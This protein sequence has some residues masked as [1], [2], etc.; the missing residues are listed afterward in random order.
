MNLAS[1]KVFLFDWDGTVFNSMDIK[2]I[3]FVI[4]FVN[5]YRSIQQFDAEVVRNLYIKFSGLPR[6]KLF[7]NVS[8]VLNCENINKAFLLFD[9]LFSELNRE[10]LKEGELFEDAKLFIDKISRSNARM[11]ISS[12]VPE[13]ELLTITKIILKPQYDN[14]EKIMGTTSKHQKGEQHVSEICKITGCKRK[15]L[16]FFGDDYEDY[17]LS[18]IAGVDCIIIDRGQRYSEKNIP[19]AKSFKE[20]SDIL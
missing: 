4:A 11:F 19:T 8:Q 9:K 18:M 14:F 13:K 12:S 20:L 5:S 15:D 2:R 1:K 7:I 16:Q 3:N 10:K 17:N 6:E